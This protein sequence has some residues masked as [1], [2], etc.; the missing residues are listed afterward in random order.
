M[1]LKFYSNVVKELKR[2]FKFWGL[3]HASGEVTRKKMAVDIFLPFLIILHKVK[4]FL[5]N[6]F[7]RSFLKHYDYLAIQEVEEASFFNVRNFLARM[8]L[9]R[10][11]LHK[12]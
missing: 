4:F 9:L 1:T 12:K 3:E 11:A 5:K 2:K 7:V 8:R 10:E 6:M